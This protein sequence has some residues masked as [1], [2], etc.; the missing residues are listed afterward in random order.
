[1]PYLESA[2]R[3]EW[4]RYYHHQC[5]VYALE[6]IFSAITG[7][8]VT[9]PQEIY[10]LRQCQ[11]TEAKRLVWE[12]VNRKYPLIPTLLK[13]WQKLRRRETIFQRN[14]LIIHD[15]VLIAGSLIPI[16]AQIDSQVGEIIPE[17]KFDFIDEPLAILKELVARGY[18]VAIC[19]ASFNKINGVSTHMFHLGPDFTDISDPDGHTKDAVN[20]ALADGSIE[21]VIEYTRKNCGMSALVISTGVE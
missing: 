7:R 13:G 19:L 21:P 4:I 5:V 14:K 16:W 11:V 1:M 2:N 18:A 6:S 15:R 3:P 8:P 20:Q 10:R 9:A 12:E 17:L